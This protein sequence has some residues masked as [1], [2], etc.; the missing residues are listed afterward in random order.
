MS[1]GTL[2][3]TLPTHTAEEFELV[4]EWSWWWDLKKLK[5]VCLYTDDPCYFIEH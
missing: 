2:D 4:E 1:P 5:L 3:N